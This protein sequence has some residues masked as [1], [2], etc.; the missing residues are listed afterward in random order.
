[1]QYIA[2]ISVLVALIVMIDIFYEFYKAIL[3]RTKE[4]TMIKEEEFKNILESYSTENFEYEN[5]AS[6]VLLLFKD[7]TYKDTIKL[8]KRIAKDLKKGM[9]NNKL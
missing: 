7:K 5:L 3:S 1:M 9:K 2:I 6:S 4:S 8:L